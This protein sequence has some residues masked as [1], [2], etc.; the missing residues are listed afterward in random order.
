MSIVHPKKHRSWF[1][2]HGGDAAYK[3]ALAKWTGVPQN[4]GS[5]FATRV[6]IPTT[7]KVGDR[8]AR[9]G[10]TANPETRNLY[11]NPDFLKVGWEAPVSDD[12]GEEQYQ[13][14]GG[15]G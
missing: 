4:T 11:G 6:G 5:A 7:A 2:R 9:M 3:S 15:G 1:K 13:E 10:V 12:L 8:F 14:S